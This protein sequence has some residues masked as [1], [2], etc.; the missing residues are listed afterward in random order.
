MIPV[1]S[2]LVCEIDALDAGLTHGPKAQ[3]GW[4]QYPA[5]HFSFVTFNTI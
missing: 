1:L 3:H 5:I 4:Y 2:V